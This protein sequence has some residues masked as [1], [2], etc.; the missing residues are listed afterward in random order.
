MRIVIVLFTAL[1]FTSTTW[2][3]PS[4]SAHWSHR[5]VIYFA[6]T[7]DEY[8]KQFLLEALINECELKD[9]DLVTLVVTEDGFSIPNWVKDE[10]NLKALFHVYRIKPGAHT[11][12]LIGKDGGEKLRWGKQTDWQQVKETIDLI[13]LRKQEMATKANPCSA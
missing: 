8:V 2:A 3:Y 6:P 13:P 10:F 7:N 1:L 5:S 11:A 12:V 4:Y 9:R